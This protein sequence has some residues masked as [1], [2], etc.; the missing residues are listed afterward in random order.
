M[1]LVGDEFLR[2]IFEFSIKKYKMNKIFLQ[3]CHVLFEYWRKHFGIL[4]KYEKLSYNFVESEN[5]NLFDFV[6]GKSSRHK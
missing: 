5:E 6:L 3:G 4:I 2:W 1:L